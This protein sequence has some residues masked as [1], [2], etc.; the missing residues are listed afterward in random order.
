MYERER[1]RSLVFVIIKQ[2]EKRLIIP[3]NL[4]REVNRC[5]SNNHGQFKFCN[6]IQFHRNSAK[7][8]IK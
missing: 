2:V 8:K 3:N 7:H 5:F 1:E 4:K 6:H